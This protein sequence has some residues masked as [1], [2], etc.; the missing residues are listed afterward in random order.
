MNKEIGWHYKFIIHRGWK[1]EQGWWILQRSSENLNNFSFPLSLLESWTMLGKEN[2]AQKPWRKMRQMRSQ[3]LTTEG[4]KSCPL[5]LVS[6][7]KFGNAF[8]VIPCYSF[9]LPRDA[10]NETFEKLGAI[11]TL[12]NLLVYLNTVFNLDSITATNIINIFN[13]SASLSTLIGAFLCDTYF[14][15]YKTLGFCTVASFLVSIS[16][17]NT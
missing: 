5:S 1:A 9:W 8:Y 6:I 2:Q 3:R 11:G 10:G 7:S 4:G 13:G 12:A 14:G 17:F 16:I 15:R